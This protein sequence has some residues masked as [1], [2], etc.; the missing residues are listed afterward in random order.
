MWSEDN[1]GCQFL[2]VTSFEMKSSCSLLRRL[3]QEAHE[4]LHAFAF[5]LPVGGA[6]IT[7]VGSCL[8]LCMGSEEEISRP[9]LCCCKYFTHGTTSWLLNIVL[10]YIR[11][12]RLTR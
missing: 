1:L 6:K 2:L 9:Y 12:E 10:K 3:S 5:R 4:R 7:D 11:K 8:K